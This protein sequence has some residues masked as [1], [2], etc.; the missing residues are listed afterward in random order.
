MV[1]SDT[2][3][4]GRERGVIIEKPYHWWILVVA[5]L[6]KR[7]ENEDETGERVVGHLINSLKNELEEQS[8]KRYLQTENQQ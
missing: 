3:G 1:E 4:G 8:T 6:E 2:K 7:I 5:A